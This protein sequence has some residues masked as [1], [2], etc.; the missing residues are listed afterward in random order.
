MDEATVRVE[1]RLEVK[2]L[3]RS[4]VAA[5]IWLHP[6]SL[7]A[8]KPSGDNPPPVGLRV[9]AVRSDGH[10]LTFEPERVD[11]NVLRG[12]SDILGPCMVPLAEIDQLLIGTAIGPGALESGFQSWTLHDAPDP[13]ESEETPGKDSPVVRDRGRASALVGKP[14][15]D[16]E[17]ALLDGARF[18]LAARKGKIVVL[19]FWATW[20]GPCLQAMPQ[21]DRV[22][23]EFAGRGVELVAV[24]LQEEPKPIRALLERLKLNPT[25]VLDRDGRVA[26][27]YLASAIPQT[28]LIDRDGKVARVFVGSSPRLGDDLREALDSLLKDP[29]RTSEAP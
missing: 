9:Q 8:E 6:E 7:R 11:D 21:V 17:L 3:P 10:R 24:N 22:A 13:L 27:Q 25:V 19:D 4:R 14:A 2:E 5:I 18:H 16:F 26:E 20:C 1:L 12:R 15:P 29:P 23:H 28:V